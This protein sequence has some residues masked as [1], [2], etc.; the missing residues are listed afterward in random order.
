MSN[1]NSEIKIK[2][3]GCDDG[4]SRPYTE[5]A[6][7]RRQVCFQVNFMVIELSGY[8]AVNAT[9][10]S[11]HQ[12]SRQQ[13]NSRLPDELLECSHVSDNPTLSFDSL[14][15][16]SILSN[17]IPHIASSSVK[18]IDHGGTAARA[19]AVPGRR[20]G[21]AEGARA[22]PDPQAPTAQGD[23]AAA[24]AGVDPEALG[25]DRNRQRGAVRQLL[26]CLDGR[27]VLHGGGPDGPEQRG[28][29]DRA[30][31]DAAAREALRGRRSGRHDAGLDPGAG[32]LETDGYVEEILK[33]FFNGHGARLTEALVAEDGK[34]YVFDAESKTYVT[35]ED[36][37]E[38]E[39]ASI[40]EA[41]V[42]AKAEKEK[43][44][45][46]VSKDDSAKSKNADG[47]I[48]KVEDTPETT[49]TT[50]AKPE[51]PA[52]AD[53][54]KKRKKKKKKKSDKWK[55]SK[56]NTWVYVNGL[57][58]DVSVQEVHDHFA[59][60]GVIQSDIATGEPRIKLYQ[61][62]DSG[63]LNVS[64]MGQGKRMCFRMNLTYYAAKWLTVQG[65]ASVC[66]MKEASVELAVQLL[67]KSQIRPDEPAG[68]RIVVIKHIFTPAEVEDEEYEK[69][70]QEDI[71][72]ECFKIGE[73]SKITLF[74]KHVDG[75]VVI[76][77]ASSGSAARCVEIMDGRFF[78]GRKLECGFWDGTDYT[79]RE[80]K[81][82]EKERAEKFKE[83]LEEG[84]SSDS[85]SDEEKKNTAHDEPNC[86]VQDVHTGRELP[87]LDEDSDDSDVES[88]GDEDNNPVA[89][90]NEVHAGRVMPDLDD[91]DNEEGDK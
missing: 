85:D 51:D 8:G 43:A 34:R 50:E 41:M 14:K 88:N 33:E 1:R 82:E 48:D 46:S 68:L 47:E 9:S 58:L 32:R 86:K 69:E 53:A 25:M 42:Q 65:D 90:D 17:H 23:P 11:S 13:G 84:S 38:D 35:P 44:D 59:K 55:K 77:F 78:A 21:A 57:P 19:L 70:L 20:H 71:H 31:D 54:A 36:K 89:T 67:D 3:D 91:L 30:R 27:V 63:G 40:Q 22:R 76:K 66:Y 26:P 81:N 75:V 2:A 24:A 28:D 74:A 12:P 15:P 5:S 6:S 18:P 37:I 49:T 56:K 61:N 52:D 64:A 29:D 4:L 87:P 7:S 79:H 45:S 16:R 62:K 73:V 83:W 39:L 80:S 10:Q 72:N 60:C